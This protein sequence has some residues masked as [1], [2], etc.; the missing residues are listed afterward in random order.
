MKR[1]RRRGAAWMIGGVAAALLLAACLP[2]PPLGPV[3]AQP[4]SAP[5][6]PIIGDPTVLADGG[7]SYVFGSNSFARLPIAKVDSLDRT[8]SVGEWFAATKEG[9]PTRPAWAVDDTLWAPT[10]A[11][12]GGRYVLFFAANRI[13]APDPANRQCI[14][15]AFA[16]APDGPYVPDAAPF[17]CGLDGWRGAL[18]PAIFFV[19]DGRIFLY[20]AF[21]GTPNP[22]YAIA[23]TPTGDPTG[24]R[25]D[26]QAGY[27]GL[28]V[29]GK[30][31]PWEGRFIE[32]PSMTYD[33]TTRTY[34]LAYSA[35]DW[36]TPGYSTGLARC[37]TP[38]GLCTSN[39][40]G[41]WLASG[42][43]RTGVGGLSFFTAPDGS[44][45]AIYASFAAGQEGQDQTRAGSVASVAL[46]TAPALSP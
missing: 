42:N 36:W 10:V 5:K 8:Y 11:K 46:G 37:S 7:S 9:M 34:L 32:N 21:S 41:P 22:I 12:F 28:P 39:P 23:L 25:A 4:V 14:G 6:Y 2:A 17:S 38:L 45:K 3:A 27:W 1:G 19:P 43:G 26:G 15:R 20:A 30:N 44:T 35:G 16:S 13:G 33:P 24:W 29:L 18:D 40:N 31:F